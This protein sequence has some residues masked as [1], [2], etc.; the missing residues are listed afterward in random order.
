MSERERTLGATR[1]RTSALGL[2]AGPLGDPSLPEHEVVRLVHA[3]IDL[4]I[5]LVDTA[6]SYG[7]S[8]ERLG[9]S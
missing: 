5:R 7:L 1:L 9:R 8:E 3:A 4:G 6:P 2:G